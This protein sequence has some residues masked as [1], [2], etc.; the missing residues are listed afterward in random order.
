[1]TFTFY[2]F[3]RCSF[4]DFLKLAIG[5]TIKYGALFICGNESMVRRGGLVSVQHIYHPVNLARGVLEIT[6]SKPFFCR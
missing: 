3:A 5:G 1:M 6:N 4:T 2:T